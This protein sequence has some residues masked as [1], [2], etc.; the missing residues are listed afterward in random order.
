MKNKRKI[1]K[2]IALCCAV[3]LTILVFIFSNAVN[4]NPISKY[5][6]T[7][8]AETYLKENFGDT[9]FVLERLNY[10]FKS[11][12]YLAYIKSPSS[13]DSNFSI[14][15]DDIGNIERSS[16]QNDV[17]DGGNTFMRCMYGY[18]D[19]VNTVFESIDFPYESGIAYGQIYYTED[20]SDERYF[21]L[22]LDQEFDYVDLGK[23]YGKL[24]LYVESEEITLEKASEILLNLR[25][26]FDEKEVYFYEI[27]FVLEKT[28]IDGDKNFDFE[29]IYI[30]NFLYSDIYEADMLQRV[31]EVNTKT[32]I[33][34]VKADE[35]KATYIPQSIDT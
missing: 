28:R 6:A 8:S 16:Y 10:S 22:T 32:M 3:V 19:L 14:Y 31:T 20:E 9:D 27:D 21:K 30:N 25:E 13:V 17:L 35:E 12:N 1:S 29:P 18:G 2:G 5:I 15:I 26:I 4:G 11:G 24:T 7:K 34:F 33:N 23:K